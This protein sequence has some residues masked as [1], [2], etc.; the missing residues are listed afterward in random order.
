MLSDSAVVPF[1]V[2]VDVPVNPDAPE[3]QR[4]LIAELAKSPYQSAKPSFFDQLVK[5]I[6]DWIN[7]LINGLDSVAIPGAGSVLNLILLLGVIAVLVIAFLVF[8]LPRLNR[9]SAVTGE[10][11][12]EDDLRD[13]AALRR[14]AERAAAAGDY[15]TAIEELFRA[16]ARNLDERTLVTFFPG[17]TARDVAARAG[18]VFPDVADRLLGAASAFDG[19]RYLG[20]TGTAEEWQRLVELERE[21]RTAQPAHEHLV[22]EIPVPR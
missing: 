16:L 8:G 12:G 10:L 17:S 5:Q 3:A 14:D 4:W 21:V 18:A 15:T 1:S 20:A 11:F 22:D 6:E 13:A 2:P 19:V 7:S 9:R